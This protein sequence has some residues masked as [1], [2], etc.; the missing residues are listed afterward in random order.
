MSETNPNSETHK[1]VS[2][3]SPELQ[4][5][6]KVNV[7]IG[8]GDMVYGTG[9]SK[10]HDLSNTT[11]VGIDTLDRQ[12]RVHGDYDVFAR[13]VEAAKRFQPDANVNF[14]K[15]DGRNLPLADT[16]ADE[17]F[18]ANV[19]CDP[20]VGIQTIDEILRESA[21]VLKAGGR[22][23]LAQYSTPEEAPYDHVLKELQRLGLGTLVISPESPLWQELRNSYVSIEPITQR[24]R[25]N[26]RIIIAQ[27]PTE[28]DTQG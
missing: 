15:A 4:Q 22:L 5:E 20:R 19:I 28:L 14:M 21:R 7:E 13:N 6:P 17:V 18:M 27:K 16:S 10:H 8:V 2:A 24:D 23:V 1:F 26:Q 9:Y 11:Y 3:A 25:D 12:E